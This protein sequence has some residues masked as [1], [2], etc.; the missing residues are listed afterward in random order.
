MMIVILAAPMLRLLEMLMLFDSALE[1][2]L[3]DTAAAP[4][5]TITGI[6]TPLLKSLGSRGG[7]K[8]I[9]RRLQAARVRETLASLRRYAAVVAAESEVLRR[10][11][12]T[13]A[14]R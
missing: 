6:G 11:K 14:Y 4:A 7:V 9:A 8:Y 12:V 1:I 10:G 3:D 2:L 13:P 5:L